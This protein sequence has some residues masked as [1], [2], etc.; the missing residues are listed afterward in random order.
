MKRIV[1]KAGPA[2]AAR[3]IGKGLVGGIGT[4]LGSGSGPWTTAGAYALT[5]L[6]LADDVGKIYNILQ[7][8]E[9]NGE[10]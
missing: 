2:L 7:E 3:T 5:A 1:S 10:L 6:W 9:A 8:A 4:I